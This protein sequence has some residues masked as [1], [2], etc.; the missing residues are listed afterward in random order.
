M[1]STIIA[2]IL[3]A[4]CMGLRRMQGLGTNIDFTP[5]HPASDSETSACRGRETIAWAWSGQVLSVHCSTFGHSSSTGLLIWIH[6]A[7]PMIYGEY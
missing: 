1:L 7:I 6:D 5:L 4:S 3:D 2:D